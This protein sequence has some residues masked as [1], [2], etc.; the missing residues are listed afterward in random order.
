MLEAIQNLDQAVLL[1]IQEAVRLEVL[2]PLVELYTTLGNGGALWIVLSL[3]LLCRKSTRKAGA[4]ALLALLLGF[5][6]TNVVLKHLV[7]RPR[8][9]TVVEGLAPLLL[10]GDPNSFPSG[11][12]AASFAAAVVLFRCRRSFG[13]PALILAALIAFSRLFLFVHYPTDVLA[14][15]LLGTAVGLL[16]CYLFRKFWQLRPVSSGQ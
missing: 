4:A 12:S 3:V 9:Y 8:P 2:N 13:I 11:H 7:H 10:S 5:L 16:T 14:G 1:W 6:C 15:I